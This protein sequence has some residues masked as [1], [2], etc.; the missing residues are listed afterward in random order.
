VPSPREAFLQALPP[1]LR[2][3]W[4]TWDGLAAA[5]AATL[6]RV[7]RSASARW[8][9]ALIDRA[10]F[11]AYLGARAS[12]A[13][14]TVGAFCP[15]A[16]ELYLTGS[17]VAGHKEGI[18]AFERHYIPAIAAAVGRLRLSE[19]EL[20][21]LK[22]TLRLQ[23]LVGEAERPP[24][25]ADYSGR[26]P[27]G[28]WVRVAATRMALRRRR[29]RDESAREEDELERIASSGA[30][31]ELRY[32]AAEHGAAFR[33]ALRAAIAAL[34]AEDQNLLRQHHL[35][36]LTLDQLSVLHRAHRTTIAYRLERARERLWKQT[37][38]RL[39]AANRLSDSDCDS[40][41]RH[42]RSHLAITLRGLFD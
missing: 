28:A 8:G 19:D 2:E 34:S 40:L 37:R 17:I 5:L 25:I 7:E 35:D 41:F 15:H 33:A 18:A 39:R 36:G 11:A 13:P 14:T 10:W 42:A 23:L 9:I 24:R 16:E 4:E 20:D 3:S 22:Q 30:S 38:Q 12:E 21:E 1:L 32:A 6:D 26:G 29:A 27:L 31:P